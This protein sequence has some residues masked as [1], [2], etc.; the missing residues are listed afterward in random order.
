MSRLVVSV[1]NSSKKSVIKVGKTSAGDRGFR[2]F[3]GEQGIQG[4]AVPITTTLGQS[5]TQAVSQ[6]LFTDTV[7]NIEATLTAINGA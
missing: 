3:T 6:K 2:G 4:S 1:A 5:T 7:G